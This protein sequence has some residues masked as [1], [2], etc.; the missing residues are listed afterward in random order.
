[1]QDL[2][3]VEHR[4]RQVFVE[5]KRFQL[6]RGVDARGVAFAPLKPSTQQHRS[7][8]GPPLAPQGVNSDIVTRYDVRI[9]QAVNGLVLLAGWPMAWV[10]Y[11]REGG[12]NLPRRDPGG[13]REED[14]RDAMK[15]IRDWV[16]N[17]RG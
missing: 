6:T 2:R 16:V 1:M 12:R 14:K 11:H 9:E 4:L 15:I 7:G 17:G 3:P 10:K 8:T 13:F 5:G